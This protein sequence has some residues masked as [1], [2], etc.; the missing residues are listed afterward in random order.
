MPAP[1]P[2]SKGLMWQRLHGETSKTG[3]GRTDTIVKELVRFQGEDII[4]E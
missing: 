1:T 3:D 4:P 2:T